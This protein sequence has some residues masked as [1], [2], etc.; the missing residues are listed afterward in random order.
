MKKYLKI[1]LWCCG[2]AAV[3]AAAVIGSAFLAV[4][5]C[6]QYCSD[7][8][9]KLPVADIA[10][11]LG[12]AK[13]APSGNPNTY[14]ERRIIAAERLYAAGKVK[15]FLISGDNS[16]KGYDEPTDMKNELLKCGVPENAMTLDYAGFRTLDSVVR[17]KNVF[18]KQKFLVI[19]QKGHAERAVYL[20]RKNGIEATAFYAPSP[21]HLKRIMKR[22]HRRERLAWIAAWLDVNILNTKPKFEK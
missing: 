8:L 15:H 19:T 1:G 18:G 22:N 21:E 3:C 17:A 14:F 7:D 16:R 5:S 20:A 10:L 9:E 2:A 11:L 4:G 6:S 13:I 12:A